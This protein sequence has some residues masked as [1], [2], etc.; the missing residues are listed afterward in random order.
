MSMLKQIP[1]QQIREKWGQLSAR[2]KGFVGGG[3]G[4]LILGLFYV[5]LLPAWDRYAELSKEKERLE[6]DFLWLEEQAEVVA[7]L[8]NNCPKRA[9]QTGSGSTVLGRIARRNRLPANELKD[10]GDDRYSMIIEGLEGNQV[11]RF[12]HQ[13]ACEGFAL[14]HLTIVRSSAE[15]NAVEATL[16]MARAE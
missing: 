2:E 11:L 13:S 7:R 14:K 16:E 1:V 4:L 6:D 10:L 5:M 3:A 12:V 15:S 8:A 9:M